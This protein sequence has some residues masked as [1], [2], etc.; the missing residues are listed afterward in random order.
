MIEALG[1]NLTSNHTLVLGLADVGAKNLPVATVPS[2]AR[3]HAAVHRSEN[4]EDAD[5]KLEMKSRWI[6][7]SNIA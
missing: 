3:H 6:E 2:S 1:V 4:R 7:L 5:G